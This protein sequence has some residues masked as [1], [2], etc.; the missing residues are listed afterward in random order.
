MPLNQEQLD[1]FSQL[2]QARGLPAGTLQ[3]MA[4]IESR[5]G[6]V[7]DRRGSQFQGMFQ[8]GNAVRKQYGVT[9]PQDWQQS[10]QGAAGYAADNARVLQARGLPVTPVGLYMLHQQ[11][12]RGGVNLL[13]HP[14]APAGTVANPAFIA[15]NRGNPNAP[16]RD[17]IN[18]WAQKFGGASPTMVAQAPA[19]AA[20]STPAPAPIA[21][22][23]A[24]AQPAGLLGGTPQ[25][26]ITANSPAAAAPMPKGITGQGVQKFGQAL[27]DIAAR[28]SQEDPIAAEYMRDFA[29]R[30]ASQYAA[31]Q[32]AALI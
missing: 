3:G 16:A 27:S 32:K 24:P 13:S 23:P 21:A 29:Q 31:L 1:Y 28:S 25:T 10:A 26:Q 7:P 9:N 14:D 5:G 2:E 15:S 12:P 18:I 17:F 22:A 6:S 8:L 30:A 20:P 19:A 4:M 11:G